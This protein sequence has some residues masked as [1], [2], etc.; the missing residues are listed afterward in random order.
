[1]DF[2]SSVGRWLWRGGLLAQLLWHLV[3]VTQALERPDDGMYDPDD[4]SSF[5]NA[6]SKV[7]DVVSWLPDADA[8]IRLSITAAV[9]SA[10]WNPHF[11]QFNRGFTR[12]LLGFT[13]WYSF[14]GLIIFFRVLF[15]SVLSLDGGNA[16]SQSAQLSAHGATAAVMCFVSFVPLLNPQK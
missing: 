14:Q 1:M 15:R 6:L 3:C 5:A 16:R 9:A 4:T 2:A 7:Q 8:L 12:H 10:W 13:R 11:V